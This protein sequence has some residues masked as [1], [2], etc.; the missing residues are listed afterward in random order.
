ME[1]TKKKFTYSPT[2][3][4]QCRYSLVI[5]CPRWQWPFSRP[6]RV[7]C[8][9]VHSRLH[10]FSSSSWLWPPV[11]CWEA[12]AG[13]KGLVRKPSEPQLRTGF[14]LAKS[15]IFLEPHPVLTFYYSVSSSINNFAVKTSPYVLSHWFPGICRLNMHLMMESLCM[16][17]RT[18]LRAFYVYLLWLH[19]CTA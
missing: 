7:Y 8:S 1:K 14:K 3:T 18:W 4:D 15:F 13:W 11:C 2:T 5:L 12:T 16:I 17:P 6:I 19:V 9:P 10:C